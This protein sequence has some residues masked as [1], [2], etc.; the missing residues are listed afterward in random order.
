MPGV[1]LGGMAYHVRLLASLGALTST[2]TVQRRGALEHFY[3]L[4]D[5]DSLRIVLSAFR[6]T[7]PEL[8]AS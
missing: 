7:F 1:S 6:R 3:R 8:R 4:S 2:G 5:D